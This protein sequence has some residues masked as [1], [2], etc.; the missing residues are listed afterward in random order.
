MLCVPSLSAGTYRP[1]SMK[2]WCQPMSSAAFVACGGDGLQF[3]CVCVRES[4]RGRAWRGP[5][6]PGSRTNASGGIAI[7]R[8]CRRKAEAAPVGP[9]ERA[10]APRG[11]R[12][13]PAARTLPASAVA[14]PSLSGHG[15]ET[16]TRPQIRCDAIALA[17]SRCLRRFR[18]NSAISGPVSAEV[19]QTL[20]IFG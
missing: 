18:P 16:Q 5:G 9:G 19:D 20:V 11:P 7:S 8:A 4:E 14:L 6:R 3:V 17:Q 15:K 10:I 2:D 1:A 13:P 12:L